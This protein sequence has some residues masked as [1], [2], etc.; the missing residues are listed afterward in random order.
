MSDGQ[1]ERI[2]DVKDPYSYFQEAKRFMTG[3]GQTWGHLNLDQLALYEKL[4]KEEC[5]E[6]LLPAFTAFW[7]R[8]GAQKPIHQAEM[9]EIADGLADTIVVCVGALASLGLDP[10]EVMREVS[11]SNLSKLGA[12]GK[13]IKRDDGKIL[14][15]PTYSPPNLVPM[16]QVALGTRQAGD[17]A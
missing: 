7:N 1:V 15:P 13:A 10:A 11:R 8:L 9:V 2:D 5:Q 3:A 12:D 14:K 16:V 6:E 17:A 4:I